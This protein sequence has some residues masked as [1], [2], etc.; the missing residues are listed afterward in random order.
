MPA[1]TSPP[2]PCVLLLVQDNQAGLNL[3]ELFAPDP[4]RR[5]GV[6][7]WCTATAAGMQRWFDRCSGAMAG[8]V[9]QSKDGHAKGKDR[10][11]AVTLHVMFNPSFPT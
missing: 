8:L 6:R 7:R 11:E 4:Q 1:A 2:H 5:A 3:S 9:G 10:H